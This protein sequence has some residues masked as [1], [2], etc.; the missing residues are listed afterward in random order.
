MHIFFALVLWSHYKRAE[1][2][3]SKGGCVP[4]YELNE[5]E[6]G[7]IELPVEDTTFD[8]DDENTM[9]RVESAVDDASLWHSHQMSHLSV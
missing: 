4:D 2:P 6:F 8:A 5:A 1:L 9:R 7:D 3:E